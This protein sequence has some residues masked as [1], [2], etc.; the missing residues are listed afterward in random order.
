MAGGEGNVFTYGPS[1]HVKTVLKPQ[2]RTVASASAL[3]GMVVVVN[4]DVYGLRGGWLGLES[5]GR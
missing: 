5:G 3:E 1:V 2:E 4:D